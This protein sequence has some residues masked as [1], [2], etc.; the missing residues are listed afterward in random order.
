MQCPVC[1]REYGIAH[2]C[3]G[4]NQGEAALAA[5][6]AAPAGFAPLHYFRKAIAIAALNEGAV[7]AASQE[8]QAIYYGA[9]IWILGQLAFAIS[10]LLSTGTINAGYGLILLN[11]LVRMFVGAPLI[12]LQYAAVHFAARRFF[13][14]RGKLR[15]VL[16][17]LLLGS[18]VTWVAGIPVFPRVGL[19]V[20]NLWS[21]AVMMICFEEVDRIRRLQ[22]FGLSF[23]LGFLF[24]WLA[25]VLAR[26]LI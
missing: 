19:W 25:R 2:V 7:I 22:A 23:A 6:W 20:A 18:I 3:T 13:D 5:E 4:P 14:A 16:G 10:L 15:G 21:I 12:L 26:S 1:G 24:S 11:L 8:P 9:C 17:P